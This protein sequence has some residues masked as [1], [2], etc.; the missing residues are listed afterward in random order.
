MCELWTEAVHSVA[1]WTRTYSQVWTCVKYVPKQSI[2]PQPL[3]VVAQRRFFVYISAGPCLQIRQPFHDSAFGTLQIRQPLQGC[4]ISRVPKTTIWRCISYEQ[5]WFSIAMLVLRWGIAW[6]ILWRS[7]LQQLSVHS[8]TPGEF[9]PSGK[10]TSSCTHHQVPL[11]TKEATNSHHP[12][13]GALKY[14]PNLSSQ[15]FGARLQSPAPRNLRLQS[16]QSGSPISSASQ[17]SWVR[18]NDAIFSHSPFFCETSTWGSCDTP[19][20][21]RISS[22]IPVKHVNLIFELHFCWWSWGSSTW[23]SFTTLPKLYFVSAS[24]RAWRPRCWPGR[25]PSF[26]RVPDSLQ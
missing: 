17:H 15:P 7:L 22:K 14:D 16:A 3:H 1:L 10:L 19:S 18:W 11:P 2:P 23:R 9:L 21:N 5:W 12:S 6:R 20:K 4:R 26:Q 25:R 13:I 24:N 8:W